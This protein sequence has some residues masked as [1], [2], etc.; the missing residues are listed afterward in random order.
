[1]VD[2]AETVKMDPLACE[3]SRSLEQTAARRTCKVCTHTG[4]G[5]LREKEEEDADG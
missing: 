5:K 4:S 3:L 1:M 2:I